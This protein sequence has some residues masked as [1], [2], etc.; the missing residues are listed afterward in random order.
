MAMVIKK[1][2]KSCNNF[3][4][5]GVPDP[6]NSVCDNC[7]FLRNLH[8]YLMIRK[9]VTLDEFYYQLRH[10]KRMMSIDIYGKARWK[11]L[12]KEVGR[13]DKYVY[14]ILPIDEGY[15]AQ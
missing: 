2:R 10:N 4:S 13:D 6:R 12:D 11:I 5:T 1:S 15:D 3:L 8:T 9:D 7:G 14:C